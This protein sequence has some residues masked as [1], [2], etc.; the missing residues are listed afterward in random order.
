M[1]VIF[2]SALVNLDSEGDGSITPLRG[3]HL[4][5]VCCVDSATFF[6]KSQA[7][8]SVLFFLREPPLEAVSNLLSS[9]QRPPVK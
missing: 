7:S 1:V 6:I 4:T 2:P 9:V 5:L 3:L 8:P